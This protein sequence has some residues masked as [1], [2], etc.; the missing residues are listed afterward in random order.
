M[1]IEYKDSLKDIQVRLDGKVVGR[2]IRVKGGFA[3][4]PKGTAKKFRGQTYATRE[5]VKIS[6]ENH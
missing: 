2:I 3:Y 1:S 5:E 6:I 4:H